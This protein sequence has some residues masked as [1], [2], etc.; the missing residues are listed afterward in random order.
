MLIYKNWLFFIIFQAISFF[1]NNFLTRMNHLKWLILFS[2]LCLTVSLT[3]P[4][5]QEK[6]DEAK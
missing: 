5:L 4:E 1:Y 2:V 3:L 6:L